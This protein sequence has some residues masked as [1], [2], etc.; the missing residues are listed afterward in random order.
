M[1][2]DTLARQRQ[3]VFWLRKEKQN[4]LQY[5]PGLSEEEAADTQWHMFELQS[6]HEMTHPRLVHNIHTL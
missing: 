5:P 1:Q 3:V 6:L 2:N 4:A